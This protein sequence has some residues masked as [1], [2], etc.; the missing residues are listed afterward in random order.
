MRTPATPARF[1]GKP[2]GRKIIILC[3]GS[4]MNFVLGLIMTVVL[5]LGISQARAPVITQFA[6]G[7]QNE[8]ANGLMVGDRI[9]EVDGHGIWLYADVQTYLSRNDGN[10][11]DLVVERDGTRL[12]LN[13]FPMG[14][15]DY[16]FEGGQ[17]H[18]FG[19]IF[20][21]VEELSVPQRIG[22][23]LPRPS[24]LYASPG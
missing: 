1:P 6:G 16:E 2:G 18:G 3:A 11:V 9:V 5:F 20:G 24:I 8:G 7:F 13:N 4:F 21:A 15:Y 14:R 19:L 22:Q 10:G 23:G 17:Y 12:S